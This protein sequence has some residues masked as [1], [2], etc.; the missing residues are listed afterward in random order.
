MSLI[1]LVKW[2]GVQPIG[3]GIVLRQKIGKK[4]FKITPEVITWQ[5]TTIYGSEG[6]N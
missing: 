1:T 6:R 3:I 5:P 4:V 2:P